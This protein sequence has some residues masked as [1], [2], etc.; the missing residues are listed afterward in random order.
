MTK[1]TKLISSSSG[2]I[3]PRRAFYG[4]QCDTQAGGDLRRSTRVRALGRAT[5]R[6]Q[7]ECRHL[8]EA[9]DHDVDSL[10]ETADDAPASRR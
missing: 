3:G 10:R 5:S 6:E 2:V 8:S 7:V 4:W 9:A 1:A